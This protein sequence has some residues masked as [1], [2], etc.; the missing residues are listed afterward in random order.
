VQLLVN[1]AMRGRVMAICN[2]AVFGAM[3]LGSI[4][5]G[6]IGEIVSGKS[7]G[8]FGTQIGV[9]SLA[10][11]LALSGIVM[12]IWRTPE[13]DGLQPGDPGYDRRPGLIRGL[14]GWAHRP[15][16]A[17]AHSKHAGG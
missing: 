2:V 14:T 5:A 11:I 8:G 7:E 1:D 16:P 4:I 13:V 10:V 15:A 3:P 17:D 6:Y 9:G 12:L